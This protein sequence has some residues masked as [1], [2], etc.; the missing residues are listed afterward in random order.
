[1]LNTNLHQ[2]KLFSIL[3][4]IYTDTLLRNSL[5]FKG[6]TCAMLF[7]HLPRFSVD[8]DFDLLDPEK[9]QVVFNRLKKILPQF[10]TLRE[11]REKRYTLF[12]LLSYQTG[13]KQIKIDISKRPLKTDYVPKNYLGISMMAITEKDAAATK[14]S[15]VLTR[16]KSASRDLFD[17]WFYLKNGFV[18]NE[19]IVKKNTGLPLKQALNK[20]L[21][22]VEKVKQPEL[23]QGLGE[24]LDNKQKAWVKEELKDQLLFQ[25][26]L[27]LEMHKED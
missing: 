16:K 7:Y 19:K 12:F 6:G 8:L 20:A 25:I 23:L 27:Y 2:T 10:G 11:T 15:A 5:G 18:L 24:L 17:L 21:E 22:Q 1:M 9:K 26:K 3:Q 4:A 14:L 13:E